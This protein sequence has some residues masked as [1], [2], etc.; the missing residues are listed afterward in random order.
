[1]ILRLP[2]LCR[3]PL[4]NNQYSLDTLQCNVST[5]S[6]QGNSVD[7]TI[8]R[9]KRDAPELAQQVIRGE[10]SANAAA[11]KAGFRQPKYQLPDDPQAAGRYLA[12]RVDREWFDT[13]IDAYYKAM[14]E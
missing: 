11:I 8:R 3:Y 1:M 12:Q 13:L 2:E 5:P 4:G 6:K 14:G 9:L 10:L 7:Y